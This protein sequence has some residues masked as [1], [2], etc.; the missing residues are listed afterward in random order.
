MN[1]SGRGGEVLDHEGRPVAR[2]PPGVAFPQGQGRVAEG[3]GPEA[4]RGR[5]LELLRGVAPHEDDRGVHGQV[6]DHLLEDDVQGDGELEAGRDGQVDLA[7]GLD[8]PDLVLGV[9]A[10]PLQL[11]DVLGGRHD[12]GLRRPARRGRSR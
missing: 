5:E 2:H 9:Q 6:L 12:H 1:P 7:Q 10:L 11:G 3:G 4:A 8:A